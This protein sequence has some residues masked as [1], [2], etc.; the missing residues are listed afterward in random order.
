MLKKFKIPALLVTTGITLMMVEPSNGQ[1]PGT[2]TRIR[3][4]MDAWCDA[5]EACSVGWEPGSYTCQTLPDGKIV[6]TCIKCESTD[7][8]AICWTLEGAQC[9]TF[10]GQS[11][12]CGRRFWGDCIRYRG[13]LN[14]IHA[15]GE[16]AGGRCNRSVCSEVLN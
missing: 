2:G 4:I 7:K 5:N 14:C 8:K 1:R 16:L 12:D 11:Q 3:T 10:A 13:G 15:N 9:R 6:G